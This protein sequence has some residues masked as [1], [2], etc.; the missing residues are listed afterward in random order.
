MPPPY[1]KKSPSRSPT[2]TQASQSPSHKISVLFLEAIIVLLRLGKLKMEEQAARK[3]ETIR[4]IP[5]NRSGEQ[6]HRDTSRGRHR[7]NSH[8]RHRNRSH[9]RRRRRQHHS[10]PLGPVLTYR[11]KLGP[12]LGFATHV[13]ECIQYEVAA[14]AH[15]VRHQKRRVRRHARHE[16]RG[17]RHQT[18]E[19]SPSP[20]PSI[21]IHPPDETLQD[22]LTYTQTPHSR[23]VEERERRQAE[24]GSGARSP[25]TSPPRKHFPIHKA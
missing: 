6:W 13:K 9:G 2:Q 25:S 15:E 14:R 3:S 11:P 8:H 17:E 19:L 16:E 20:S 12:T 23:Q 21:S 18:A 10:K 7:H 22:L 5:R 4:H 24:M 1:R